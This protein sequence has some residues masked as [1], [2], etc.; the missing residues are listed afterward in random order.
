MTPEGFEVLLIRHKR[1]RS[2]TFPKGHMEENETE[3]QTARREVLEETGLTVQLDKQ[4]RKTISISPKPGVQKT[5][6]I[7]LGLA[8]GNVKKQDAEI[9]DAQWFTY[10]EAMRQIKFASSRRVLEYAKKAIES[11]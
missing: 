7:F 11:E 10:E 5:V 1:G 2:W 9:E 8:S 4:F 6:V 3:R